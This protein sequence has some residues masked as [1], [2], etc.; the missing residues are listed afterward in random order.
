MP[1][2]LKEVQLRTKGILPVQKL[3]LLHALGIITSD[4]N[5]PIQDNQFQPNSID[6]RLG[7][8]AYRV[9]CSFLPENDSVEEKVE[10]LKMY[11]VPITDGAVLEQNCVY[12]IPLL[13]ELNMPESNNTIQKGLFNGNKEESEVKLGTVENLSAKANPKSS[14]GRLDVFTRVITDYSHRFEEVT[15]GY[16][17][18]MYLEVVPKSFSIKVKTGQ[19]L[20][21]LRVRHG[22]EVLPDQDLLR[23]HAADPLLFD[24][25]RVPVSMEKIKVKQGLFMSVDLKGKKGDIIGYKAKKHNNYIDLENIGHYEVEEFWEPI[26]AQQNDQLI[27]EP[28]AFY[29]FASKERIR[30]P[31]HLACEM[32]AYDTGSGEL[33]THYAGFFDSGFG[34]SVEDQ[35]ARAV[36][37][38]RSHDVPF[39]IEDGQTMFSMQF[40]PNAE[41]PDFVYGEEID[42]NYQG[43]DL[44]LGKHFKQP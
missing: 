27:L 31:A 23:V 24:E 9:R 19:R 29:I 42:S 4:P 37:E 3:K 8:V 21:Q 39:M 11:E 13:E 14:T 18:K 7:E 12:I 35:G 38:V 32:M 36:L 28:E 15:P 16:R 17:G 26:Y 6:L 44:K 5:Y 1:E 43:Q 22:F 40:E 2:T 25:Q 33:R 20:N 10:K 34:G 30:V 41:K